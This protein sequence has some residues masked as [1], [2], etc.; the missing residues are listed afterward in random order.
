MRRRFLP[1]FTA[2]WD[3]AVA[4]RADAPFLFWLGEDGV[5]TEWTY[6]EFDSLVG[7][8]ATW[9]DEQGVGRGDSV[10][11]TLAS[12]PAFVAIWLATAR[13]G[14]WMVP[15]DPH[16]SS[17]ELAGHIART[18][19][20]VGFCAIERAEVYREA[21][22]SLASDT[23]RGMVA[24][25]ESDTRL[26]QI[27]MYGSSTSARGSGPLSTVAPLP[28]DRLAVMFTSGTTSAPKGVELTQANYAFAGDVMAAAAGLG[29]GDRQLV[30]L[31]LFHANAQYYSFASAISA[32]ASVGLVGSFSA[33]RFREQAAQLGATHASLFAAPMRMILARDAGGEVEGLALRHVWFA[34][35]LTDEQYESFAELVGC[36]PRQLYGMT[37]TLPAV[38]TNPPVGQRPSAMGQVTLGCT[39]EVFTTDAGRPAAPGEVGD[40]VVGGVPGETLFMQYLDDSATTEAAIISHE[41]DGVVWFRTGDR[42]RVDEEG[43]F[44][45][46]GRSGDVLKVSGENVSIVEVEEVLSDHPSVFEVA[47]VGEPDPVRDEVPVAYVVVRPEVEHFDPEEVMA[48]ATE[49]LS[50]SK[51]PRAVHV[52]REL[53]RTSVGKIRKFLLGPA[54]RDAQGEGQP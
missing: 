4:A 34:Q 50:P 21:V 15:S 40:L 11:L 41:P 53:P 3:R 49:R 54:E 29:P 42:G 16:A 33:S 35:N 25:D 44:R 23:A 47:V 52:V 5:V 1:T 46:E 45:F 24:I 18:K 31:P 48:W 8:V 6:S 39:V 27:R 28:T 37:E 19:P 22:A 51:R 10:H 14:A 32:G 9:L 43:W 36:H 30:V 26:D 20:T 17:T 13:L 2:R 12:S 7:E 38:L